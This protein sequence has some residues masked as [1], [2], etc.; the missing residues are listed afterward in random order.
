MVAGE[1]VLVM[2]SGAETGGGLPRSDEA[3][4]ES[5]PALDKIIQTTQ[6]AA[7]VTPGSSG[8][9]RFGPEG[10]LRSYP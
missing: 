6:V 10:T 3:K 5:Y 2:K 1:V 7:Y 4:L 9:F 8:L